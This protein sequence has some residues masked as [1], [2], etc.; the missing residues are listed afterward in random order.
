[1]TAE[2]LEIYD[3]ED[4]PGDRRCEQCGGT[5]GDLAGLARATGV[6]H[7]NNSGCP[8]KRREVMAYMLPADVEKL[9]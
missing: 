1:M 5:L 7:C 8:M 2:N 3:S 6:I 9:R 4:D